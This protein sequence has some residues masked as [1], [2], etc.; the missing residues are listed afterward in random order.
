VAHPHD[1]LVLRLDEL[2]EAIGLIWPRRTLAEGLKAWRKNGTLLM[3]DVLPDLLARADDLPLDAATGELLLRSALGHLADL[4]PVMPALERSGAPVWDVID[5]RIRLGKDAERLRAIEGMPQVA[6]P[7]AFD[8][9]RRAL[10]RGGE[11]APQVLA[12]LARAPYAATLDLLEHA[13]SRPD[14]VDDARAALATLAESPAP[15]AIVDRAREILRRSVA[16]LPEEQRVAALVGL[17]SVI[18][19]ELLVQMAGP[20]VNDALVSIA[21][22]ARPSAARSR[23]RRAVFERVE[24]MLEGRDAEPWVVD[25]LGSIQDVTSAGLLGRLAEVP[26][27]RAPAERA[28][29]RLKHSASDDVTAAATKELDRLAGEPPP[30]PPPVQPAYVSPREPPESGRL[31]AHYPAVLQLLANGRLVPCL[32]AG[33][34]LADRDPPGAW[35]RGHN[36]PSGAEL[37]RWLADLTRY[38]EDVADLARVAQYVEAAIG[39]GALQDA[40]RDVFAHSFEPGPLHRLLA[41]LPRRFRHQGR[42]SLPTIVSLCL[43]DRLERAFKDANEPFDLLTY[44]AHGEHAG[45]FLYTPPFGRPYPIVEPSEFAELAP[46]ERTAILKLQ[47]GVDTDEPEYDSFVLTEDDHVDYAIRAADARFLPRQVARTLGKSA[48]LFLG[49]SLRDWSLRVLVRGLWSRRAERSYKSWAV[50]LRPSEVDVQLWRERS[51]EIID[52]PLPEYVSE[53]EH[54]LREFDVASVPA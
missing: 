23:A 43:D 20:G 33:T 5:E 41:S 50:Q 49:Y 36:L 1:Y 34:A 14:L 42:P 52:V 47:G 29:E 8:V 12:A 9:L 51:V 16:G 4:P 15:R 30:E 44:V 31:A 45:R 18:A 32:G 27:R 35:E 53:L 6:S 37:A 46:A 48:F 10:D 54:H 24:E 26:P 38:P 11:A 3:S 22:A 40:L 17:E 28:L 7:A 25:S 21:A 39:H 19:V 13:A 2:I